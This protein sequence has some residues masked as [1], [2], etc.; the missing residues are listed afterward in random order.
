MAKSKE[1]NQALELRRNGESIKVI[2]NK[3]GVAKSTV[4]LWCRDIKLT[5]KQI[6]ILHKRMVKGGYKGRMKGARMQYK[7]RL[8]SI[9]ELKTKGAKRL[10]NLSNKSF[11]VAGATLY[12]GEGSKKGRDVRV[13]NSDPKII[14][15]MLNWFRVLWKVTDDR[16]SLHI[17]INETHRKR[18][19]E[20]QNYWSQVTGIS[21]SQFTKPTFIKAENKKIYKNFSSHYGTLSLNV[22]GNPTKL[23][24]QILGLIDKLGELGINFEESE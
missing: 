16:F 2:A 6:E 20:V 9:E 3:L 24:R 23:I 17:L 21:K 8:R 22:R 1:K 15:F 13:A 14:K 10:S 4:S 5:Q 11:L 18:I 7:R 19:E 12:W